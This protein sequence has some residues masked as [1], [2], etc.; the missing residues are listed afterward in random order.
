MAKSVY[1]RHEEAFK[2]AWKDPEFR[3]QY[4]KLKPRFDLVRE[5]VGLRSAKGLT[6]SELADLANT[7]QSRISKIESAEGDVTLRTIIRVADALDADVE[8][9]LVPRQEPAFFAELLRSCA[10]PSGA[11]WHFKRAPTALPLEEFASP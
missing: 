10:A 6:Q 8:L 7:H 9:R 2:E 11:V 3:H 5:I 4:L 1:I